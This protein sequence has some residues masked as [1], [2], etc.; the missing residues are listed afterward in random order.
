VHYDSLAEA[1]EQSAKRRIGRVE[2]IDHVDPLSK[3]M[4]RRHERVD[5]AFKRLDPRESNVD[6]PHATPKDGLLGVIAASA[7]YKYL[8]RKRV[9]KTG[10]YFFG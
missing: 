1:A 8:R 3:N 9:D 2:E 4:Q 7:V 10:S 6:Q 5:H